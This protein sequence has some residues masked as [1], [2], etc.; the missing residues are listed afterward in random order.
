MVVVLVKV[1]YW[2]TVSQLVVG[3]LVA[4]GC[5]F[6]VSHLV[7]C[8]P[9]SSIH[10]CTVSSRRSTR[11]ITPTCDVLMNCLFH[12]RTHL[13]QK[14]TTHRQKT[15]ARA[16]LAT[17]CAW[18]AYGTNCWYSVFEEHVAPTGGKPCLKSMQRPVVGQ[19]CLESIKHPLAGNYA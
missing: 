13:G 15:P 1:S 5:C 10:L 9:I 11:W 4:V 14:V 7:R 8:I 2:H 18:R 19:L 6:T 16:V 17:T 3:V 12:P